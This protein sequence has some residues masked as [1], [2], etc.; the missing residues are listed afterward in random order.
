MSVTSKFGGKWSD[1][2]LRALEA[3]LNAYK[4]ALKDQ[5]FE[6]VYVDAFAGAGTQQILSE[7]GNDYDEAE[8]YRHGSPL[9][10]LGIQ[11]PF[12]KYIFIESDETSLESLR[13]E[14]SE[15]HPSADVTYFN[16]DANVVL[17]RLCE[18]NWL[19]TGKRGVAFLDP[20]ALHVR[21]ETIQKIAET[22]AIDMWLLFPAM[23]INRMLPRSGEIPQGWKDKLTETFGNSDWEGTFYTKDQPDLFGVEEVQKIKD[24][25]SH[26]AAFITL[27]LNGVFAGVVEKP[28]IL[29]NSSGAPLF[30]L[31]FASGNPVGA[32]IAKRIAE[33]IINKEL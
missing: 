11:R 24:I 16:E 22:K 7:A 15:K 30:L 6:L 14:I 2:K 9:V 1:Q 29:K 31:Y 28:L 18:E 5:R 13:E 21:W 10:A 25:F 27:R 23:A 20:F 26:L 19:T 4:N 12:D 17:N 3:Y 32:P 33:S 8:R